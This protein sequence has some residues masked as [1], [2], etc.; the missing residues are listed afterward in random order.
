MTVT[1]RLLTN[2]RLVT[3]AESDAPYGMIDDGALVIDKEHISF[4]GKAVDLPADTADLPRE[5]LGGRLVTPGL[6]DCHT[7]V[8]FGG[9]RAREFEM[10]LQGATYEEVA[11]AGGGIVSTVKATRAASEEELLTAALTRVDA[12]IAEGVTALEI[13]SGY[14]LDTDAELRMLRTARRIAKERP[15]TVRTSFLGAHAIPAEYKDRADAYLDE[16]CLPTL[17]AAHGEGL[18]DAVDGFCEGIAFL[19]EQI[20]R[21]F[22]EA[23][24]LGLPVKLHAEQLSNLGG[25]ALAASYGAL[26]ADH[27]EY[28]DEAG[29]AAMAQSGSVAVLLPGAFYTLRETQMPPMELLRQH[30]VPIALATDCNPGSSPLA[31]LLLTMNMGCTL[32]RMTPEEALAGVTRFAARALGLEDRGT[33]EAGKRADL[34]IWNISH[35]AELSYRIGFNALEKRIFGGSE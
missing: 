6:I 10:R 27:L 30:K 22:D 5:D 8:V 18:V 35:P 16:V 23:K 14:G 3:L 20:K 1:K 31:S 9:D 4:V 26:S 32:F 34:A 28:L 12:L 19:P 2:A 24:A 33:L 7:H 13:K 11:R 15:V 21:V 29:V 25:T 17:E